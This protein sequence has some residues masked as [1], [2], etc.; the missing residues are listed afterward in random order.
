M[1]YW[2]SSCVSRRTRRQN[3][4]Y[5]I[6]FHTVIILS[7]HHH[8][9]QFSPSSPFNCASSDSYFNPHS[10]EWFVMRSCIYVYVYMFEIK[11][12]LSLSKKDVC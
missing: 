4:L 5:E 8:H 3:R 6:L 9:H 1:P 7:K 12:T 10:N 2:L 11:H